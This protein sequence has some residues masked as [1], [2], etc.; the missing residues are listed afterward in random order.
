VSLGAL[1]LSGLASASPISPR[2]DASGFSGHGIADGT[3]GLAA[4]NPFCKNLGKKYE[5][6]SG[7]QMFCFGAQP[8]VGG[9]R[10]APTVTSGSAPSNVNAAN[11]AE[12]VTPAGARMYGQSETSIAAA[13]H[14]VV[15]AWN[16]STTFA[17]QCNARDNKA[18]STGIGFS[19]NGGQ[20]FK[21]LGGLPNPHCA[22][23]AYVSDPSVEAYQAGGKTYF[24]ISSMLDSRF[25]IGI[26]Y[27]AFDACQATGAGSAARLH[28]VGPIIAGSSKQCVVFGT[29]PFCSFLD[30]DFMAIDPARGR[31]YVTPS[32]QRSAD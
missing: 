23:D 21:D 19:A 10:A 22:T 30:K 31:I 4:G 25:G 17:S 16:G 27:I 5:A 6:S 15:E 29:T 8:S 32:S 13:S 2:A 7:A 24:Y 9:H 14:Y 20:S 11:P 3:T 12:D 28:C 18:E 26:S 1:A